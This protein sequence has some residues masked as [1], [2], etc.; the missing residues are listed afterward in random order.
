[1]SQDLNPLLSRIV[2]A[3]Y[4]LS[5]EAYKLLGSLPYNE[6][7][8]LIEK[9]II[10]ANIGAEARFVLDEGFL[11]SLM[12][13][14][15]KQTVATART[16]HPPAADIKPQLKLLQEEV[17]QPAGNAEGFLEYFKSRF[18]RLETI[19]RR[20]VDVKD[21]VPIARAL[22]LPVKTKLKVIGMVTEKRTSGPRLFIE[23]EDRSDTISVMATDPQ[24]MRMG[25]EVLE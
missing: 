2:E 8:A 19:L 9:A 22:Q 5:P 25:L 18:D 4:Q 7:E 24:I 23:I 11:T 13:E 12:Q 1:M 20:R 17:A 3:G 14:P 21:A 15:S 16:K 6:A 10:K